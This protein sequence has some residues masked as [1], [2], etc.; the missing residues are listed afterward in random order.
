MSE[1]GLS[2]LAGASSATPAWCQH[3][4]AGT[5]VAQGHSKAGQPGARRAPATSQNCWEV[6]LGVHC[7]FLPN[8][9]VFAQPSLHSTS[10]TS[11]MPSQAH[12]GL[13]DISEDWQLIFTVLQSFFLF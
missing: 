7:V 13:M 11:L 6:V 9:E 4:P 2:S 10:S 1:H 5:C 3:R 8:P 12:P